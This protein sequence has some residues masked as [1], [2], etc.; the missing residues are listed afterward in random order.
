M[1]WKNWKMHLSNVI[2][3]SDRHIVLVAQKLGQLYKNI[4]GLND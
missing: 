3:K 4:E 1:E 2:E